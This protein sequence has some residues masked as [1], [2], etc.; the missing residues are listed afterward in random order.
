M[1]DYVSHF[2][3]CT[4]EDNE[5]QG[6]EKAGE[7][8]GPT[9]VCIGLYAPPHAAHH[10]FRCLVSLRFAFELLCNAVPNICLR[11]RQDSDI[12]S[13]LSEKNGECG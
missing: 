8:A 11:T 7:V 2:P 4:V 13:F 9:S 1:L 6:E 10:T 12:L 3:L 5:A